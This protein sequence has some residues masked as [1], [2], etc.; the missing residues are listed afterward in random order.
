MASNELN[1]YLNELSSL[2]ENESRTKLDNFYN[3][4]LSIIQFFDGIDKQVNNLLNSNNL[5]DQM[6]DILIKQIEDNLIQ[7]TNAKRE[8]LL[9]E[10][11]RYSDSKEKK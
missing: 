8:I 7:L 3:F 11:E 1:N 9:I 4:N 6:V 2:N 5:N 10:D